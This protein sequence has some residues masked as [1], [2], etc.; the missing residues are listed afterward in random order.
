MQHDAESTVTRFLSE[1]TSL[2]FLWEIVSF[3][4]KVSLTG[5]ALVVATVALLAAASWLAKER[6]P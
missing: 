5:A 2:E 4:A 3:L 6:R 1:I